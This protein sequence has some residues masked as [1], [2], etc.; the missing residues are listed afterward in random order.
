M[1]LYLTAVDTE[2]QWLP[3]CMFGFDKNIKTDRI[4][5]DERIKI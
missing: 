3:S 4:V 2:N 5:D 1:A